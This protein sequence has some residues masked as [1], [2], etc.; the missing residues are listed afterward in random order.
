MTG[1]TLEQRTRR[2][3]DEHLHVLTGPEAQGQ[4]TEEECQ[5]CLAEVFRR[6]DGGRRE[7][8]PSPTAKEE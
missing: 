7:P 1:L 2:L 3:T 8:E 6:R 4:V 5:A